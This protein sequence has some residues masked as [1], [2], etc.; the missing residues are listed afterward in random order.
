[1]KV[2]FVMTPSSLNKTVEQGVA[3]FYCQHECSDDITWRLNGKA[4]SSPNVTIERVPLISGGFY[5]SLLIPTILDF[6]QT[7]IKCVAV[8]Y[9]E[10]DPFQFA[11]SVTLLIQGM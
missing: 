5:S 3:V 7:I 1:M 4:I 9:Q 11:P 2:G 6:N 10:T 8:F